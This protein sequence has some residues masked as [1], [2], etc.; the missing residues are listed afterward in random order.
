MGLHDQHR[1]LVKLL[2]R[3]RE[4]H[5]QGVDMLLCKKSFLRHLIVQPFF[6]FSAHME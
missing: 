4:K 6:S 3:H 1:D 5:G 2:F